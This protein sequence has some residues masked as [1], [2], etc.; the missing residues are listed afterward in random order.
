MSEKEQSLP[1]F[2]HHFSVTTKQPRHHTVPQ[3][4]DDRGSAGANR[5]TVTRALR[6]VVGPD[7]D[8]RGFLFTECL[9]GIAP[10]HLRHQIN[11]ENFNAR[12]LWHEPTLAIEHWL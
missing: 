5:I 1:N 6:P 9:N 11:L 7:A 10:Q 3:N 12:D 4:P 2:L 8:H